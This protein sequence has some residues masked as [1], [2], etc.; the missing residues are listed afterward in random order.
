V[1]GTTPELAAWLL[2]RSRG[3]ELRADV[4]RKLPTLP[5]WL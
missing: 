2:G 3:K 5:R 4:S 1:S